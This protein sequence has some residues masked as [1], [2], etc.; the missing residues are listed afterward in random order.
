[1]SISTSSTTILDIRDD[2]LS[3]IAMTVAFVRS[4]HELVGEE[5]TL[6]TLLFMLQHCSSSICNHDSTKTAP[7]SPALF[8]MAIKYLDSFAFEKMPGS[9]QKD[10]RFMLSECNSSLLL[11]Y[12]H[13]STAGNRFCHVYDSG[14]DPILLRP[15]DEGDR[16]SCRSAP[17]SQP[18]GNGRYNLNSS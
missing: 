13:C 12:S 6:S 1:M 3:Q 9:V 4:Q 7:P 11:L 16:A 14:D 2:L 17:R 10:I 18:L 8:N 5:S 15:T